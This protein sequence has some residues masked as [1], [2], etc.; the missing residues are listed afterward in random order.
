MV[1]FIPSNPSVRGPAKRIV[2]TQIDAL[3]PQIPPNI[4]NTHIQIPILNTPKPPPLPP[5]TAQPH[6]FQYHHQIKKTIQ[7]QPNLTILQPM[8]HH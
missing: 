5:L 7:N 1:A 6:N 8:L 2:L 3:G 4:H